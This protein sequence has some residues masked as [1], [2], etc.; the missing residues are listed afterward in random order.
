MVRVRVRIKVRVRVSVKI[1]PGG[2]GCGLVWPVRF[3]LVWNYDVSIR[4]A[5]SAHQLDSNILVSA[6]LML[7]FISHD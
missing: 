3:G 4:R 2:G 6:K 1:T 7:D 5:R